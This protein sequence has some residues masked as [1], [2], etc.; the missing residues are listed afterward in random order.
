MISKNKFVIT[1]DS[2]G[3]DLN[4]P[5]T[6]IVEDRINQYEFQIPNVIPNRTGYNFDGWCT[7]KIGTGISYGVGETVIVQPGNTTLYAVWFSDSKFELFVNYNGTAY[8][9]RQ[10]H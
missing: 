8:S 10:R 9:L 7:N 1:F 6:I 2:N 3:G 4:V 5:S